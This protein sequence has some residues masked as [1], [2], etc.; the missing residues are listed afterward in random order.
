MREAAI[1]A[2]RALTNSGVTTR[3]AAHRV[4]VQFHTLYNWAKAYDARGFEGLIPGKPTGRKRKAELQLSPTEVAAVRA[5]KILNNRDKNS[6]STPLAI[7][8]TIEEG[9]LRPAIAAALLQRE[10]EGKRMVTEATAVD[11]HIPEIYT[12]GFRNMRNTR[13][14]FNSSPGSLM[15]TWDDVTGES[16]LV[17]PGEWF[18]IDDG[19]KNFICTVPMERRGDKCWENFQCIVGRWQF[20]LMVDHASYMIT[21]FSHTARPKGSYRA[22]DLQAVL[23]IAFKQHGRWKKGLFEKG[24]SKASLLHHTLDLAGVAYKHVSSPHQKVVEFIFN[25]LWSRLSFLPGQVGRTRGEEAEV[26]AI[27]RSCQAGATDP[28]KYFLPL[29][30]VLRELK[31]VCEEWNAHRVNSR[32]YGS[33][34]PQELFATEAK[35]HLRELRPEQEWIFS[36]TVADN[37][38]EGYLVRKQSITT[39]YPVMPGYSW[40]FDFEAPWLQ[41]FYGA[42]VRLHFNAFEPECPAMVVLHQPWQ[43]HPKDEI[44]GPAEQINM[45]TRHSRRLFG[46]D[47]AA[48]IGLERTRQNSQALRRNTFAIRP[49]GKPGVQAH[50]ARNGMGGV[51]K[52]RVEVETRD[53][54][55]VPSHP[56]ADVLPSAPAMPPTLRQRSKGVSE[57]EFERQAARLR[58]DAE[59]AERAQEDRTVSESE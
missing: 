30:T 41:E 19:T 3:R 52:V 40:R 20:L 16:R 35:K 42:R 24:I 38:G 5:N 47:E 57:D 46:I 39:S 26:D 9:A 56:G 37:N 54:G 53:A 7:H 18:T 55:R 22:E 58:L 45:H 34:V 13:L 36:P 2:Y 21:G 51:A 25:A 28:R 32:Q 15:M 11:L 43:G 10:A 17:Q 33:W 59:R 4:G 48:D 14:D 49:E 31:A 29:E 50:E 1:Q 8:K 23:H 27:V 44:L 12:R 6:G